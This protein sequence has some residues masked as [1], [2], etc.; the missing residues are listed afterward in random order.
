[1]VIIYQ[2]AFVSIDFYFLLI[3]SVNCA[4]HVMDAVTL[5]GRLSAHQ[6]NR[7]LYTFISV[8]DIELPRQAQ[9]K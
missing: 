5:Y 6:A 7:P 2:Y 3:K 1:M 8:H 4:E 9:S